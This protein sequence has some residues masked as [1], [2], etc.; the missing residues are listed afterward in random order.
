MSFRIWTVFY[1][2]AVVAASLATFGPAGVGAALVALG[3]WA[4]VFYAPKRRL[5]LLGMLSC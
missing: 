4:W 2:L 3:V 1:M 5:A